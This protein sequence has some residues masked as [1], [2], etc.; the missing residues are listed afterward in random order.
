MIS[1]AVL[2]EAYDDQLRQYVP[3]RPPKG[4]SYVWDGPVLRMVGQVHGFVTA[5]R[6]PGVRGR[7]LDALIARQRDFFAARGEQVE[8]KTYGHD[9]PADLVV[10]LEAAGFAAQ[11]RETLLIG[12]ARDMAAEPIL[13]AGVT[14]RRVSADADLR[15]I[16]A[17]QSEVWNR[18]MAWIA[19]FLAIRIAGAP[20]DVVVL[21]AEA[22]GRVVSAAWLIVRPGTQF[23]GLWG[24]STLAA[25][26]NKGIYQALVSYRAALAVAR[27][28]TYLQVDAS[29]DSRPIL[30]R[31]GFHAVTTTTPYVWSP[32]A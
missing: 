22:E 26:R 20:D 21:V 17:M 23:A 29:D 8:W 9:E 25:W 30:Q 12:I 16:E 13:P 15:A 3:E 24:G 31:R 27:G 5:R 2:L 10:R 32:Q 11:D 7:E 1:T 28:V 14:L 4:V 18:D 19:E 6:D